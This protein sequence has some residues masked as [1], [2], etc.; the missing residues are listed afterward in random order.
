MPVK[1]I[2]RNYWQAALMF[3][4]VGIEPT[5]AG[6]AHLFANLPR[7]FPDGGGV[8]WEFPALTP[9][10][11]LVRVGPGGAANVQTPIA[12][13]TSL[14]GWHFEL[15]PLG[16]TLRQQ[17]E[18][19]GYTIGDQ[20]DKRMGERWIDPKALASRSKFLGTAKAVI[21]ALGSDFMRHVHRVG[22]TVEYVAV[23]DGN[24]GA[25]IASRFGGREAPKALPDGT[26]AVRSHVSQEFG[27]M[28]GR[29]Y[30]WNDQMRV[31][32]WFV[33][34]G[35]LRRDC[36]VVFQADLKTAL[37]DRDG[38]PWEPATQPSEP[39]PEKEILSFFDDGSGGALDRAL[40]RV[41]RRFPEGVEVNE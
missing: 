10:K 3:D 38:A 37:V 14:D 33:D 5:A 22:F 29:R 2:E 26:T 28:F 16:V 9:S 39:L 12:V 36:A 27:E 23:I 31:G 11:L 30:V 18:V 20:Q 4:S 25:W 7:V 41:R 17:Q 24:P 6:L 1:T 35:I 13:G 8:S 40:S 34:D 15:G 21:A 19:V 32:N